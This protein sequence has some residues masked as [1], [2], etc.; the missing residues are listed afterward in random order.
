MKNCFKMEMKRVVRGRIFWVSLLTGTFILML[1]VLLETFGLAQN[2]LSAFKGVGTDPYTLYENW[3][4]GRGNVY[5]PAFLS[6][7]PLLSASAHAVTYHMDL[8]SGYIKNMVIKT[9]RKNYLL[10]KYLVSFISGGIV[11][12]IPMVVNFMITAAMLP[13][14]KPFLGTANIMHS[15][16]F[17]AWLAYNHPFVRFLIFMVIYFVYGG[18]FACIALAAGRFIKN[19]FLLSLF[20]FVVAYG[21]NILSSAYFTNIRWI[22]SISPMI[23]L[24][25]GQSYTTW[26]AVVFEA[27][28]LIVVCFLIYYWRGRKADVI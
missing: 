10:A 23:M 5:L 18:A 11:I 22:K 9:N 12:V 21:L 7:F 13:A 25:V 27:V 20:P 2:P 8:K 6:I 16:H 4:G 3:A 14:I 1:Q 24:N 15:G 26:L 19:V 17:L 28:I